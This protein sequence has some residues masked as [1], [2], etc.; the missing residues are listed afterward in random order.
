[1]FVRWDNLTIEAQEGTA[2]PGYREPAVV[3]HFDAPEAL[4]TR[5]YEV[6]A[7]SALN[8]VPERS[9]MPFR[10]TINPYRGC[11]HA[12]LYCIA[13]DTPILMADGRTR[14]VARAVDLVTA[15]WAPKCAGQY[16]RYVTTE[17]LA[18]WSTIKPAYRVTLEDGTELISSGDHRFL[19]NRGWKFVTGSE[20]GVDRRP[21]LTTNNELLGTG[22]FATAPEESSDY[23]RGY[24]CGI[25]RG[26]GHIGSY[27]VHAR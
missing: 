12:C 20:Q 5:F 18:H 22:G 14:L 25:V 2:L 16:R 15:S 21:H 3:R 13:P 8:R 1:M 26:D 10:W 4:D 27:D 6:R 24:L 7:K 23:R 9:R 17:V 19:T 11:S